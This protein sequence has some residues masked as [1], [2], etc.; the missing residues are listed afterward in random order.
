MAAARAGRC[1]ALRWGK[2]SCVWGSVCVEPHIGIKEKIKEGGGGLL[3]IWFVE[4]MTSFII[5]R[6]S[7]NL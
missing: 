5:A 6:N 3:I 2:F 1:W 7:I 4:M